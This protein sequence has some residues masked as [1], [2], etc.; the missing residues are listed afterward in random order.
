MEIGTHGKIRARKVSGEWIA[1]ARVRDNDGVVRQ[2]WRKR[3]SKD[4]AVTALRTAIAA[5]S[6]FSEQTIPARPFVS[7]N[8]LVASERERQHVLY[9]FFDTH[10][11][12]LYVGIS[13]HGI[14]RMGDHQRA[15]PWWPR[16]ARTS[17]AHFPDRESARQAERVAIAEEHPRYN[18]AA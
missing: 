2:V 8:R 14:R 12:L 16:V 3:A 7:P 13:L 18:I 1:R 10:D 6:G 5:R 9:R 4:D 15:Q 11:E 17:L